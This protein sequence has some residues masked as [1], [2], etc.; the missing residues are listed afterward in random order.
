MAA[1]GADEEEPSLPSPTPQDLIAVLR[2]QA[3]PEQQQV[4]QAALADPHSE[5]SQWAQDVANWA[6]ETL[7]PLRPGTKVMADRPPTPAQASFERVIDFIRQ[8]RQQKILTDDEFSQ[9]LA[10]VGIDLEA[11]A[12]LSASVAIAAV[13]RMTQA[14]QR[15]HPELADEIRQLSRPRS[16]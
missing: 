15:L 4:V 13:Q 1:T 12:P 5:L 6:V 3:T 9:I 14:L 11:T 7:P 16:R 8:K 10:A 2:G